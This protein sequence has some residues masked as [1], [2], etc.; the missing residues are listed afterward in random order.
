MATNTAFP[1]RPYTGSLA[2]HASANPSQTSGLAGPSSTAQQ[3]AQG[4]RGLGAQQQPQLQGQQQQQQHNPFAELT[5]EQREEINEAFQLFDLDRDG[6]ID[7][8][9]FKVAMKALGFEPSKQEIMELLRTHGVDAATLRSGGGIG[10][11][12]GIAGGTGAIGT[13]G[14]GRRYLS[15]SAF[16]ALMAGM[17]SRRD[18]QTEIL[19]AFELFDAD[20]KGSITLADL[21]RVAREL[22]EGLSDEELVAMIE[23]FDMDGD[24]AISRDD[25]IGIC[26]G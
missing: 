21:R 25:F 3:Q 16:Q 4:N 1:I 12:K 2:R 7:Y 24:G 22:G 15:L 11:A 18:P 9:E 8:H 14:S 17:I 10:K 13:V 20:G 5:E 26:L 6:H 23:E 19:R